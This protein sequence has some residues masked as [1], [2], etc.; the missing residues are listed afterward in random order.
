M[1]WVY[2]GVG[3]V[4]LLGMIG[5]TLYA[6]WD[7][8]KLGAGPVWH[9]PSRIFSSE[10]RIAVGTNVDHIGLPERLKRLRYRPV[11]KVRAPGE[12]SRAADG[13][14]IYLHAFDYPGL[15]QNARKIKLVLE[16]KVVKAIEGF[17]PDQSLTAVN[18]EPEVVAE[19]FDQGYEDRTVVTLKECPE[20][21][22]NAIIATEDR[23]FFK[24]WGI[25]LRSIFRAG[26]VNLKNGR[27]VEGGSTIT[28]QLVKNLYLSSER[29]MA[30]KLRET[31]MSLVMEGMFSK[32]DIL[33]MYVNE[34]YLGQWGN[35]G[36]YGFGRAA[37][38]YFDKDIKDLALPEAALLAGLIRAPNIY[39]PYKHPEEARERRNT[40]LELMLS[41]GYIDA[42]ACQK[43][44]KAPLGV[45]PY[46]PRTRHAPYFVDYL[47]ASIDDAYPVDELSRGGYRIFTTLDM[48]MQLAAEDKLAQG[49]RNLSGA[50]DG[51][52]GALVMLDPQTGEIRAMVGGESYARSQF[53]R[54][55]QMR[56]QIGSLV[57]PFVYYAAVKNGSVLSRLLDDSPLTLPTLDGKEWTPSNF[58]NQSHGQVLLADALINSYNIATVRLGMELGLSA[59]AGEIRGVQPSIKIKE[60]PSLLLGALEASPLTMAALYAP[61][62]NLGK[63]VVPIGLKAIV[64]DTSVLRRDTPAAAV[65]VMSPEAVYLVDT[66]LLDVVRFGTAKAAGAYGMPGGVYGKTGTTNDMRDAWFVGFTPDIVTVVWVGNDAN[67]SV[68]LSGAT[69][70]L[71]IA[72]R[73]M[74]ATVH[75][76]PLRAP[77]DIVFCDIDPENGKIASELI[78]KRTLAY[79]KGTEPTEVSDRVP[80]G[81]SGFG[82][83]VKESADKVLGWVKSLF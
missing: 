78:E 40:V 2:I 14:T 9:I 74:G 62:A 42:K 28:Q 20:V 48:N 49:V 52:Q 76:R 6:Y 66:C 29:T 4:F 11:K 10:T 81:G 23:R 26:M 38:I 59:V 7:I 21:L 33:E 17:K 58:D 47:L 82:E 22:I 67:R 83:D 37:R 60:Q 19:I 30:R 35:A 36:I 55:V 68:N 46:V 39:S 54:A 16:G 8:K 61:F 50:G 69:G 57:K 80:E 51:V 15:S 53:N 34:I 79:I 56:R 13:F 73:V 12:Y 24:N 64:K 5:A 75:P 65:Q 41:Q 31:W 25:D 18:L 1:R 3:V 45:A 71:P 32:R 27:I 43:A 63:R 70:A 72:S 77:A 44:R